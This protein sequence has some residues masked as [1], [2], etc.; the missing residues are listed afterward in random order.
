[1]RNIIRSISTVH[2]TFSGSSIPSS[3]PNPT[4]RSSP[5]CLSTRYTLQLT[6]SKIS[7][8]N[9]SSDR[10]APLAV[11]HLDPPP[12]SPA[13]EPLSFAI[14][15]DPLW[16][17]YVLLHSRLDLRSLWSLCTRSVLESLE[18]CWSTA[19]SKSFR[20][21][22]HVK[23]AVKWIVPSRIRRGLMGLIEKL[24][25][26]LLSYSTPG[27]AAAIGGILVVIT[28]FLSMFLLF[29]HLS[30][31]RNPEVLH[32]LFLD[33]FSDFASNSFSTTL[34]FMPQEQ[35]FLVGVILMVPCYSI[36]SL[37]VGCEIDSFASEDTLLL[38]WVGGE[39]RTIEFLNRQGGVTSKTTLLE[40]AFEKGVIKHPFPM[41]YFLKPWRLSE[42]FYQ[43]I[44][45]GIV[46]YM[47]IKTFTAILAVVLEAFGV[48]CE[49]EFK[50]KCGY[51]YMAVVLNFSQ[52]W[53]LY[54]LVLFYAAT[55]DELA[56]IKPLAKFLMFKS[57]VFLTWWQGVAIALL[58]S[59][60]L[61]KSPI[62][63][64][65]QFKSSVQDFIICIEVIVSYVYSSISSLSTNMLLEMLEL[66]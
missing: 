53:A 39:E 56:H 18:F 9:S 14:V 16:R 22:P 26:N 1:M 3:D 6:P 36:E 40:N 44:K 4:I 47:I 66:H 8:T 7:S 65:L 64:S 61:F 41:N 29:Q 28:L 34:F 21:F 19:P 24:Y 49:G 37:V 15:L 32:T 17:F 12:L 13:S 35:K 46:Q 55:K 57:I 33:W 2:R 45:I 38:A 48:Y 31:Y 43:N 42:W 11:I 30:S 60:G 51:T 10:L 54:C 5:S 20:L 63:Q 23:S 27:W 25:L 52:S 62:A 50:W 58:Y 59:W